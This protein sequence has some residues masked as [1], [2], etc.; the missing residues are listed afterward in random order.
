MRWWIFIFI[1]LLA[2]GFVKPVFATGIAPT[3]INLESAPG[4]VLNQEIT[5][6]NTQDTDQTYYLNS[7]EFTAQDNESGSPKFLSAEDKTGLSQWLSFQNKEIIVP[8]RSYVEIPFSVTIPSGTPA[9]SY[10]AA[11]TV[12][13]TPSEIVATNG[14]T[15]QAE[16]ASLI[17]LTVT[18]ETA[19]AGALLDFQIEPDDNNQILGSY[20][21]R[22]QNQG[23]VYFAPQA[24]I[25]LKDIFGRTILT[26]NANEQAGRILP[27]S[28][29]SFNGT[30]GEETEKKF[31]EI[32]KK[33]LALFTAGP[34]TARLEIR[35]GE[36]TS[37]LFASKTFVYLPW[38]MFET[39]CLAIILVLVVY[40]KAKKKDG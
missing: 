32:L 16:T 24:T 25:T 20:Q 18:G 7:R 19:L 31:L 33:Q 1:L 29:R 22:I 40:L 28:T 27:K 17:F 9:G 4:M 3:T 2:C 5:I 30:F 36:N 11:I 34:I 37:P 15:V 12:G 21:F 23:N 35:L 39:I 14:A 10:F 13:E 8:A 26:I 6:I 38:E